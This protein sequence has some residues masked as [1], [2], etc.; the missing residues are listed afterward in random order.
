MPPS[1]VSPISEIDVANLKVLRSV[2]VGE[3][4]WGVVVR[5]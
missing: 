4:P 5:P 2:P 1:I 3:Q